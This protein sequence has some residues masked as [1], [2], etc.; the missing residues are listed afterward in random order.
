MV[1]E[2]GWKTLFALTFD[3]CPDHD[4][5]NAC[6][7]F[8]RGRAA[9]KDGGHVLIFLLQ[10]DKCKKI[11]PSPHSL[12]STITGAEKEDIARTMAKQ[13]LEMAPGF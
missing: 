4:R 7:Q 5:F 2:A 1:N 11:V 6:R 12:W 8:I 10:C 9:T 13:G 3:D